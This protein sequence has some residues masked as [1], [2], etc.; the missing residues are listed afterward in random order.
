MSSRDGRQSDPEPESGIVRIPRAKDKEASDVPLTSEAR[1]IL[2]SLGTELFQQLKLNDVS[3][4][5]KKI[6]NAAGLECFNLRSLRHSF[7]T[8]LIFSRVDVLTL[9]KILGHSDVQTTTIYAKVRLDAKRNAVQLFR[10]DEKPVT[11]WLHEG[12]KE[13][14]DGKNFIQ[15]PQSVIFLALAEV[16]ELVDALDSKSSLAQTG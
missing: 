3:R 8:R 1:E 14:D 10:N 11:F 12:K 4:P 5:F 6:Y 9:S 15:S 13:D 16:A 7:A 2:M